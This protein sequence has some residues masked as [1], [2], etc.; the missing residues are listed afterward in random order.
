MKRII[1]VVMS[2]GL[3]V[4]G[5]SA[6][7]VDQKAGAALA[8]QKAC[9]AC[10]AVSQK[11]VGPAYKDVAKKY[12]GN[13]AAVALLSAR[14]K[15]GGGGVWGNIPMPANNVTDAEAKQLVEWILAQ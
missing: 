11:V 10:H 6:L 3:F 4:I 9:M 12:K 1:A 13:A 15:K 14:V 2:V 5:G 7:A 8:Q